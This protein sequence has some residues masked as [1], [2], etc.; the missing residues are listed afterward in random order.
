MLAESL[1]AAHII[2]KP[3]HFA[4]FAYSCRV[5]Q[6]YYPNFRVLGTHRYLNTFRQIVTMYQSIHHSYTDDDRKDFAIASL[7]STSIFDT[8]CN[9]NI[10]H[11]ARIL[12]NGFGLG[13]CRA[14]PLKW[15]V[16]RLGSVWPITCWNDPHF[17]S[18]RSQ[19]SQFAFLC[20]FLQR[21]LCLCSL[22]CLS[23]HQEL[24][25]VLIHRN[26]AYHLRRLYPYPALS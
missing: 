26:G 20:W 17:A 19:V 21:Y 15:N 4:V 11:H 7:K 23:L 1:S 6:R 16:Q 3:W 25:H 18:T 8:V 2:T 13:Q 9:Q 5:T 12:D 24:R 10:D 14:K 22:H